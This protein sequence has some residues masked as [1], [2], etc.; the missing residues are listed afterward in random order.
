MQTETDTKDRNATFTSMIKQEFGTRSPAVAGTSGSYHPGLTEDFLLKCPQCSMTF[1]R[2]QLLGEHMSS[3]HNSVPSFTVQ[4]Q[5]IDKAHGDKIEGLYCHQCKNPFANKYSLMKHLRSTKCKMP[6]EFNINKVIN[7][8]LT[9]KTCKHLFGSIQALNKH[10]Q[11]QKCPSNEE[12]KT[13]QQSNNAKG[14]LVF[15]DSIQLTPYATVSVF[16]CP[17]TMCSKPCVTLRAFKMH[18]KCVH[19]ENSDL[20]PI[21]EEVKANYICKVRGCGKLFVE[22]QQLDVHFKHHENYTPRSGKHKCHICNEAFF[23]KDMLKR[24]VLSLHNEVTSFRSRGK[25]PKI[26]KNL[27][28]IKGGYKKTLDSP[29]LLKYNP[30][31]ILNPGTLMTVFKCPIESCGKASCTDLKSFKLHCMHIHQNKTL[32]PVVTQVE[33][34]YIC[35]VENCGKLYIERKQYEIHQRHHKTYVPSTG[36]YYICNQC[37]SKFNSQANL[38]VHTIQVHMN[39]PQGQTGKNELIFE[40]VTLAPGTMM[41]VFNCPL[42]SCS[43]GNYL[44]AK[45]LKTHC[46][47]VHAM[48]DFEP[49]ASETE[50]QFICQVRG[51]R[52]LFVEPVQIEAHLK[53]HRNYIPTNGNF[54]CKCCP[55]TFTRKE[56]LDQHTLNSHTYEGILQQQQVHHQHKEAIVRHTVHGSLLTSAKPLTKYLPSG[57]APEPSKSTQNQLVLGYQCSICMRKFLHLGT[58][59]NHVTNAHQMPGLQPVEVEM[60]PRYTCKQPGCG[61]H[62]MTKNMHKVHMDRHKN[63]LLGKETKKQM[64]CQ[65]CNRIFSQF[66]SLHQHLIQTHADVTP[67]EI[68]QL[69]ADHA[70]CPICLS[71]FRNEDILKNHMKKH[72]EENSTTLYV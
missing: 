36:R 43:K 46:R 54:E 58:H 41:A 57:S 22:E 6:D 44:D 11:G 7:E 16:K 1:D 59:C 68:A 39:T 8:Q 61:K 56:Q 2:S 26:A 42:E 55:E 35:Q 21:F 45:S 15:D 17:E 10:V 38:D 60:K 5:P 31:M 3:I 25:Q 9:C 47:R 29:N 24:H 28:N 70:K 71:L 37:Q 64:K 19:K 53:H 4:A 13:R 51:C 23:Q 50:A 62:F 72:G 14:N 12:S 67:D 65:K 63:N 32:L 52:K 66:K 30:N 20:E 33:A 69:E 18:A 49:I 34:K 27:T 48:N 40:D